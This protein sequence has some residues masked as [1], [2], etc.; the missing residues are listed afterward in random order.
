MTLRATMRLQLHKGFTFDDAAAVVPY[1]AALGISHVYASPIMTARAGS[2]HGYDVID[3][4]R[5][6]PELGGEQG[7]GRLSGALRDRN[8][9]LI[10]DIVPNHM[11]VGS[12]NPWWMDVLKHGRGSRYAGYFDIDWEPEESSLREKVLLPI[13]GKPYGDALSAGEIRLVPD[14]ER[15]FVVRY[16]ENVLPLSPRDC[17]VLEHESAESFDPTTRAGRERL[18]QL[19]EQQHYRLA[20]WRTANDAINWRRFF[21]INGLIALSM[22]NGEAFNAVHATA[23]RLYRDGVIDG[24]RIDHVDGLAAPR[25]YCRKLRERL[26]ALTE[27]GRDRGYLAVEKILAS[28][29][30]LPRNWETEGTTGYDFMDQVSALLHDGEGERPLA[31]LWARVTGRPADFDVEETACRRQILQQS[32]AG[33]LEAAVRAFQAVAARNLQTRD[34]TRAAIRRVLTEIL[35]HFPVY[36]VYASVGQAAASD[37]RFLARAVAQARKT[38]LAGD[39]CLLAV[40][41]DWLLGEDTHSAEHRTLAIAITRFQQLSAPLSAKAV[42]DTA[43]YR[44]GRLLSRNDVGFDPR[45]FADS[46]GDFH[47]AA[48][49][50]RECFPRALLATATH[51]HKRGEDVRA[52][53]AVLSELPTEWAEHLERWIESSECLRTRCNGSWAPS[54]GDLAILFQTMV[55]SWPLDLTLDDPA[56]LAVFEQRIANWQQKALREAK[57]NSDWS[58]PN[59]F[60]E[61]AARGFVARLFGDRDGLL[62]DIATF[63]RRLAPAGVAN[64]LAQTLLKLTAPG[65]PDIYQGTE[66]WDFSLVDPDNR[67]PVDFCRRQETLTSKPPAE[68]AD[69]WT[70]DRLKQAVMA[71]ALAARSS[72]PALFAEGHYVRLTA[73]GARA[74]HVVAFARQLRNVAMVALVCRR[75][76]RLLTPGTIKIPSSVWNTTQLVLPDEL[77][78]IPF[79]NVLDP[80]AAATHAGAVDIAAMLARL[81]VGL[82]V[83][84]A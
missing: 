70:D 31:E 43:F 4:A 1:L 71:R 62:A 9:G 38:C 84:C 55:G 68:F 15:M 63:A 23:L 51:D 53:L 78:S 44:F 83:S 20:W 73:E 81:P 24:L 32:F 40:L 22:E 52:R 69:R 14:P 18:H 67:R 79:K 60:Y 41:A 5:V 29:E 16:F 57:L 28:D 72:S 27:H 25:A 65:I 35:T 61:N 34:F 50:R 2:M 77:R 36:R 8:M 26:D 30:Q 48:A 42:E 58:E 56:A 39:H 82:L 17:A 19:L 11:A 45:R 76:A 3:P 10:V 46:I 21:D 7:L 59:T 74:E 6:N 66:Y 37:R 13:L 49:A 80:S 47:R 33:Q 54:A 64:S 12:D 75:P